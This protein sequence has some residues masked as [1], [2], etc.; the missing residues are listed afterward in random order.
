M[1]CC[2]Y[3]IAGDKPPPLFSQ[4][5]VAVSALQ[6]FRAHI[7]TCLSIP[8]QAEVLEMQPW[9]EKLQ[10]GR[11]SFTLNGAKLSSSFHRLISFS[12]NTSLV[13]VLG[14]VFPFKALFSPLQLFPVA[15]LE[16]CREDQLLNYQQQDYYQLYY[17]QWTVRG[18]MLGNV[19]TSEKSGL[20]HPRHTLLLSCIYFSQ[21]KAQ[22]CLPSLSCAEDRA[23]NIKIQYNI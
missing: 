13:I 14:K 23:E 5:G 2:I 10:W 12:L 21:W 20:V 19:N 18:K 9:R 6:L 17:H 8:A 15:I 7:S 4:S 1:I 3:Q 22:L 16:Q 11:P